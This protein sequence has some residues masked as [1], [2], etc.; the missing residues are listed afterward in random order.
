[1]GKIILM[2]ALFTG[3]V[4]AADGTS[5]LKLDLH[6]TQGLSEPAAD[7][8]LDIEQEIQNDR[9]QAHALKNAPGM[10]E[11]YGQIFEHLAVAKELKVIGSVRE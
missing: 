2:I 3:S 5:T 6:E 9:A 7:G 4:F 1:M 8:L 11:N 10:P